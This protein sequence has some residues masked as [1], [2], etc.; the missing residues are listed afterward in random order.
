MAGN[1]EQVS[2]HVRQPRFGAKT[3]WFGQQAI[4]IAEVAPKRGERPEPFS[5]FLQG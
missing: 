1:N 3:F 4:A 5:I 2:D